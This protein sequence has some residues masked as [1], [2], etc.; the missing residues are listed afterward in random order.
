MRQVCSRFSF[1]FD[2]GLFRLGVVAEQG[3]AADE[4]LSGV[5]MVADEVVSGV[6][7]VA[8]QG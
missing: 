7:V 3:W 5:E 4:V 2:L 6:E 1:G 8:E